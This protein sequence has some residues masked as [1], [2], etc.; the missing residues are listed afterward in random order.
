MAVGY[1]STRGG[2]AYRFTGT[3]WTGAFVTSSTRDGGGPGTVDCLSPTYCLGGGRSD[4][5]AT[6]NGH[7]W[8]IRALGDHLGFGDRGLSCATTTFC[9]SVGSNYPRS[10]AARWSGSSWDPARAIGYGTYLH[11][12]SCPTRSWCMAVGLTGQAIQYANGGW[13][14]PVFVDARRGELTSVSC[15]DAAFCMAVDANGD[16]TRWDGS[17]WGYPS[18][19]D[20]QDYPEN[21][22][23][24]V[25]CTARSFCLMLDNHGGARRWNGASW[26]IAPSSPLGGPTSVSCVS[27]TFCVATDF[28]GAASVFTGAGWTHPTAAVV[29]GAGGATTVSCTTTHFCM[30]AA[31]PGIVNRFDGSRWLMRIRLAAENVALNAMACASPTFC[32]AID[33]S[34]RAF[35]YTGS[36]WVAAATTTSAETSLT[37]PTSTFC[38]VIDAD[39]VDIFDGSTWTTENLPALPPEIGFTAADCSGPTFC[40]AVGSGYVSVR[41]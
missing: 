23:S 10:R 38:L 29:S 8:A 16:A 25:S 11:S 14:R 9:M 28:V 1:D 19:I 18:K 4:V 15:V 32:L 36:A 17:R 30:A 13:G 35:R 40:A 22:P 39:T 24:G 26:Q 7:A 6:F 20:A 27:A 5:T 12:V 41:R 31:V 21:G 33:G 34:G 37:C 3:R 2:V